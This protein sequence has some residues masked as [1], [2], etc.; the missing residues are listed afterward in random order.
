SERL[1]K[2]ITLSEDGHLKQAYNMLQKALTG[3]I[4]DRLNLPEA[5]LSNKEYIQALKQE[6]IDH[7]LIKNIRLLLDKCSSISYAP[8]ASHEYLKSHVGLA[9]STLDKLKKVL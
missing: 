6:D 5:G 7:E 9:Q 8:S 4:G 3:F 2:A 1:D